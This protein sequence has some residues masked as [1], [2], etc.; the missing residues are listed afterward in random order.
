MLAPVSI[1]GV[2]KIQ[3]HLASMEFFGHI[4]FPHY[5]VAG[6]VVIE[7]MKRLDEHHS[8]D[9]YEPFSVNSDVC[10]LRRM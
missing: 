10:A 4:M 3:I 9:I 5:S 2:G 6:L 8:G 1:A 7:A